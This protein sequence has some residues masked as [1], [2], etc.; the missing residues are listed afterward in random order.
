MPGS[1]FQP[2]G[3]KLKLHELIALCSAALQ[4][5][6]KTWGQF[7][8][9]LRNL[10]ASGAVSS[11]ETV[12]ILAN[13]FTDVYLSRLEDHFTDE[14]DIDSD[15]LNEVI[16]RVRASYAAD[17]QDHAVK[18]KHATEQQR[19]LQLHVHQQ[20]DKL[21]AIITKGILWVL[22]LVV[23]AALFL[24]LLDSPGSAPLI[25]RLLLLVLNAVSLLFGFYIFKHRASFQARL[26]A[27]IRHW[28]TGAAQ[29]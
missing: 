19:N 21:A 1:N 3:Q 7:K 4:P 26:A 8:R 15:S 23:I 2:L 14:E 27:W 24:S 25:A 9:H 28:L 12:A 13:Q 18:A 22:A 20:A 11:D 5:T 29:S 17:A 10:Q 16:E 6:G